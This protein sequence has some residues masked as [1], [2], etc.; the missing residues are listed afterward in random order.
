MNSEEFCIGQ[1]GTSN[2]QCTAINGGIRLVF[3]TGNSHPMRFNKIGETNCQNYDLNYLQNLASSLGYSNYKV[4]V[5]K[6]GNSCTIVWLDS[7]GNFQSTGGSSSMELPY[8][9]SFWGPISG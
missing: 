8:D 2:I 3:D 5:K 7:N 1:S 6:T 9:I 4:D